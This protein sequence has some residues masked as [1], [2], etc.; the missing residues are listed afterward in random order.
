[1]YL[2]GKKLIKNEFLPGGIVNQYGLNQEGK[3]DQWINEHTVRVTAAISAQRFSSC[4][5]RENRLKILIDPDNLF[6][7]NGNVSKS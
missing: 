2:L 4:S 7:T 5:H 1:M 3:I 6:E